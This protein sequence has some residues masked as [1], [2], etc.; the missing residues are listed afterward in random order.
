M[1]GMRSPLLLSILLAATAVACTQSL[2]PTMAGTGGTG[3]DTGA[4]TGLGS[5]GFG[6]KVSAACAAFTAEYQ[7]AF[8]A[9]ESCRVGASGQCQQSVPSALS[10]CSCPTYVTDSSALSMIRKSWDQVGCPVQTA[11]CEIFCPIAVNTTCVPSD[12]GS[13]G[14]CSYVPGTGGISGSDGGGA[15][16]GTSGSGGSPVDGGLSDCDTL[17]SEYAAVL[18]GARTCTAGA[19]SQCGQQVPTYLSACSSNC[20][21]FVTD[22]SVLNA[23]RDDWKTAGCANVPVV[24]PLFACAPAASATCVPNDAGGSVCSTRYGTFA[25]D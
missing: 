13:A 11:T 15:V 22:S 5:G 4:T 1:A 2:T 16:G 8:V 12:G 19:A 20:T 25:S 18:V 21:E 6:G 23:I 14:F 17:A 24:C 7:S 10:G 9:A 3:G